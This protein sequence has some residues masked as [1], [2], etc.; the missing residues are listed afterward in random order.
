MKKNLLEVGDELA[1]F[2]DDIPEY[3]ET[4]VR[5]TDRLA[6]GNVG[7]KFKRPITPNGS[8]KSTGISLNMRTALMT[9]KASKAIVEVE[10]R[11]ETVHRIRRQ[12]RDLQLCEFEYL[13]R[14][15]L[16]KLEKRLTAYLSLT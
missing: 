3:R 11:E 5:I 15:E 6:Y 9:P 13:S 1:H 12:L 4:I 2:F 10:E 8:V 7:G 14:K 16:N